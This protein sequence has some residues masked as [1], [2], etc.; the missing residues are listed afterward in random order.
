MSSA[1]AEL[2]ELFVDPHNLRHENSPSLEKG[3]GDPV[4][5]AVTSCND[6]RAMYRVGNL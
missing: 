6:K 4:T 3:R 1:P 2:Q 5:L